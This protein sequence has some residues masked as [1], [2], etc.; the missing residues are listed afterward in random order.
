[1]QTDPQGDRGRYGVA[2][3]F[4]G[5]KGHVI[6]GHSRGI[7]RRQPRRDDPLKRR[8]RHDQVRKRDEPP[9][10][11]AEMSRHEGGEPDPD[12]RPRRHVRGNGGDPHDSHHRHGEHQRPFSAGQLEDARSRNSRVQHRRH[13]GPPTACR[14][15]DPRE[16]CPIACTT[17]SA[18]ASGEYAAMCA[19]AR[20][21]IRSRRARSPASV[22]TR[23]ASAATSPQGYVKPV[24]SSTTRSGAQP[25]WSL[26]IT[27]RP[28]A[29]ASFTTSPHVSPDVEGRTSASA[30]AYVAAM[31]CWF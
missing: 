22:P 9:R 19:E 16:R 20:A 2:Q 17:P 29:M 15:R 13:D 21:L 18:A 28:Q 30:A 12:G 3:V 8:G 24:S 25:T 26:T 6:H 7:L 27:G 1:M 31:R 10:R 23:F 5:R 14:T 11:H 4:V